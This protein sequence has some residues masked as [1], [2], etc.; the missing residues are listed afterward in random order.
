MSIRYKIP[1]LLSIVLVGLVLLNMALS[2][3]II[4]PSFREIE[5][6]KAKTNVGRVTE[7]YYH[8]LENLSSVV[9]D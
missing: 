8:E 6:E 9:S 5:I 1:L 7:A 3:K 2:W 4:L